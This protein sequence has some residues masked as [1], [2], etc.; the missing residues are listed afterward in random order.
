MF[1]E[2][3]I[4]C[5]RQDRGG[6]LPE[7]DTAGAHPAPTRLLCG[8]RREAISMIAINMIVIITI[9]IAMLTAITIDNSSYTNSYYYEQ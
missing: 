8:V 9:M 2:R 1:R 7:E 3:E 5:S 4:F 6:D